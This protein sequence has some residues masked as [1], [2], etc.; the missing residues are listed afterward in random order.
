MKK[1][2][3][4][5]T[6]VLLV[7][8]LF[9]SSLV[10]VF[11]IESKAA[12]TYSTEYNSGT[13]DVV[14][15]TLDGTSA[16][17]YYAGYDYDRL[18]EMSSTQLFSTLQTLMRTTHSYTS[19]YNDCHYKADRTDCTNGSGNVS[20][21]YTSYSATMSQWNGWNREHVWPQSL[22]GG[23]TSGG[24]ADLHHIRPS[25]A[26]VN[27]S[28]GNKKYGE[29]GE[30]SEQKLGSNP[31][32]GVLGGTYNS[33]YFEPLDNVKGDVARICLYV[34]VRW[35]SN[36]GADSI[37]DVFQSVDVLLEWCEEDP[38][39]TWEMGRNEVVEDIQGNRN[40]FIDYPEYAWLIFGRE[41]PESMTT[42][43]GEA[44]GG[45]SSGG[46]TG[47]GTTTPDTPTVPDTPVIP[48]VETPVGAS[49]TLSFASKDQRTAF[50]STQQIWEQNGIKL[51]N[52]KASSSTDVAD[53]ASPA[54]F[55]KSSSITIEGQK[56]I[57]KIE[58]VCNTTDYASALKLSIGNE[59][60]VD[61]KTVTLTLATPAKS[62]SIS[63]LTAQVRV[64]N[65][66]VYYVDDT[67]TCDHT[68]TATSTTPATCAVS[69]YILVICEDCGATVSSTVISALGHEYIDS[70]C[71][72]SS[73][74]IEHIPTTPTTGAW[75]LV[76]DA[77]EL[78]A[79]DKIVI[80]S[81]NS[82]GTFV[83][84]NIS[85]QIMASVSCSGVSN[86]TIETIPNSAVIFTLGGRSGSWTLSNAQGSKLGATA[87]KKLAWGSGTTTW[88]ISISNGTATI[89]NTN[90]SYGRILYNVSSPRFTTY[91]SSTNAS[92]L[93][94]QIYKYTEA[95]TGADTE[96][97]S[98]SMSLGS[99][100]AMNYYVSDFDANSEYYM[101][102]NIHGTDSERILG[103]E[104]NGYLVFTFTNIPPQ[105]MGE[106]IT[107]TL[108]I[109]GSNTPVD[110]LDNY[111]VKAY[112]QKVMDTYGTNGALMDLVAD[113]LRYGAA[114][115]TYTGYN[116][117]A[118]VT[119]GLS[120]GACGSDLL[121][122]EDDDARS[123]ESPEDISGLS[124]TFTSAGVRFDFDNKIYV[125]FKTDDI[126]KIQI[127][128]NG[129]TVSNLADVAVS[130][131]N[132]V[133]A[134][135]T[136]GILATEFD[137]VFTFQMYVN[138]SLHQTI[139][140]SVNS[141]AHAKYSNASSNSDLKA[142]VLALYRYGVSAGAYV[143]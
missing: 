30:N 51:T 75:T 140:Y 5:I 8:I 119:N 9:A 50:S 77:S 55:Y 114:A 93:L 94:P 106:N 18:S 74:V 116:T 112:A 128:I 138:G 45:S 133:Y 88:T 121:P 22:G 125:K 26:G 102:F 136:D 81:P 108:Y 62:Y 122:T 52:N 111:S 4:R 105:F 60:S 135:Y 17:S 13:R 23:N 89:S 143:G 7:L 35:N 6:A 42:P 41:V 126:S 101:V 48:D 92:M 3:I 33:T 54:R 134:I 66:T 64:D 16:A 139:T 40:V 28:R 91:T 71:V 24:G 12:L 46:S 47:G 79:G 73:D 14:C 132:G 103:V 10:P 15:T 76:T 27:S 115:Q 130:L 32:V 57:A 69:G 90:S 107:A 31:A 39:D 37:T 38:V 137:D 99:T 58:F 43:S 53:Y 86:N 117:G 65:M 83:A 34:Y 36:W 141:Y 97:S 87:V 78:K 109:S 118:L 67:P 2:N 72:R 84:G 61:G 29:S 11:A 96:I 85:S 68:N 100:I 56:N 49:A 44:S 104:K 95:T 131:G 25:D 129:K 21:I 70:V 123:I 124:N 120:I 98:V 113:M 80:V 82:K 20:L 127:A 110:T 59:A 63:A 1:F 19:S 142:L